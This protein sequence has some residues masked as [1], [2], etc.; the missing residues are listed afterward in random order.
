VAVAF[1]LFRVA[2]ALLFSCAVT[3]W[4]WQDVTEVKALHFSK[5]GV[6]LEL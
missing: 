5:T 6:S 3:S 1:N 2:T 4:K